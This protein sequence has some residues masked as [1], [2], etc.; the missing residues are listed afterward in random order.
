MKKLELN[1]DAVWETEYFYT[2]FDTE[3]FGHRIVINEKDKEKFLDAW[4]AE[5]RKRAEQYLEKY[6]D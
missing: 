2:D 3:G 5:W 1:L 4:A 6:E